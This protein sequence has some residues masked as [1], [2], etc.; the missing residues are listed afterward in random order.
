MKYGL[1][2][3]KGR[4]DYWETCAE[5]DPKCTEKKRL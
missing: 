2:A 5:Q 1:F 3:K 4:E